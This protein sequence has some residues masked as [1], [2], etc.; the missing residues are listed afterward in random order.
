M[1][2]RPMDTTSTNR[3]LMLHMA[4]MDTAVKRGF[5]L[6]PKAKKVKLSIVEVKGDPDDTRDT[7]PENWSNEKYDVSGGSEVYC[8]GLG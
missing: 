5:L 1:W 2:H 6:K 8:Q 7:K 4:K 3:L